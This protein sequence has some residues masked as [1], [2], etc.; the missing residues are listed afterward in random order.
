VREPR[1]QDAA[2]DDSDQTRHAH[3]QNAIMLRP[4]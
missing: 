2:R 4:R 3:R 1:R